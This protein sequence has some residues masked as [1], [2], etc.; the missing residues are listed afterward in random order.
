MDFAAARR[1]MVDCQILPSRVTDERVIDAM[2]DLPRE[3]FVPREKRNLAYVD[4][5][6][7][8]GEGRY[9]MEPMV[10]ARMLQALDLK[11]TDVAL[12]IGCASGY[13]VALLG[14]IVDTVV[15]VESD[16]G[17]A[18]HAGK[19]LAELGIDTVAIIEGPLRAGAPKQAPYDVIFFDGAVSEV[20]TAISSQLA[21]GGRLIAMIEKSNGLCCARLMTCDRGVVSGRNLFDA[22]TPLLPGFE[23][24]SAFTF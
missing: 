18:Q 5:A 22:S 24:E 12:S 13:S 2:A 4:E 23:R 15:A 16:S 19:N 8:L 14:R 7:A 1:T 17:F 10:V 20:P 11:P 21:E 3:L 9:L 6:L